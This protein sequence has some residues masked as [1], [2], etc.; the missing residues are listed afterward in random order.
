M[1]IAPHTTAR[2]WWDWS[3]VRVLSPL[4]I[5][6]FVAS[7]VNWP[8]SPNWVADE[9]R[10][11][12]FADSLRQGG[13]ALAD[14]DYLC[15]GPGYP[16]V[17]AGW[18]EARLPLKWARF[19]NIGFL[20]ATVVFFAHFMALY[21][22]RRW[23]LGTAWLLGLYVPLYRSLGLLM[24]ESLAMCMVC[25]LFFAAGLALRTGSRKAI[26]CA[27]LFFAW[28]A[29]TK[30]FFGWV[31]LGGLVFYVPASFLV[32]EPGPFRRMAAIYLIGLLAASPYLVYTYHVSGKIFYWSSAG[33]RQL[34]LLSTP[35]DEELGR[36]VRPGGRA[37][38]A[39]ACETP[40]VFSDRSPI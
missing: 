33:G 30:V 16:L 40:A 22:P 3:L 37:L 32:R 11:V 14:D 4:L 5:V 10:Y 8:S 6:Y 15:N 7:L 18:S 9:G 39:R 35:Y 2:R 34:Y 21:V 25:G 23:A 29:L 17:L 36:L 12:Q 24:T 1:E 31:L 27:G 28:L 13:Y 19:G 20:F 26:L 38:Q